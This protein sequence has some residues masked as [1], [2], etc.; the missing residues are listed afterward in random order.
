[1]VSF[2]PHG[3]GQQT[4]MIRLLNEPFFLPTAEL[5][6]AP[7]YLRQTDERTVKPLAQDPVTAWLQAYAGARF[8][9][10][11]GDISGTPGLRPGQAV[12]HLRKLIKSDQ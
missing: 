11:K 7:S 5:L 2:T 4:R 6:P 10:T 9:S 8:R 12:L 3:R 1:M